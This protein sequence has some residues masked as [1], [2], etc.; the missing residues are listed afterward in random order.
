M[1]TPTGLKTR[2]GRR[3]G[4]DAG[5]Y[6]PPG[7][8]GGLPK[9]LPSGITIRKYESAVDPTLGMRPLLDSLVISDYTWADIQPTNTSGLD[10]VVVAGIHDMLDWCDANTGTS[11][12]PINV[13]LRIEM[14][15]TPNWLKTQTG[16]IPYFIS[17]PTLVEIEGGVCPWW[18]NLDGYWDAYN[19]LDVQ[20][21]A[22]FG[23]HPRLCVR[24]MSLPAIFYNEPS[25]HWWGAA[26]IQNRAAV[27]GR[28]LPA[29]PVP[30]GF[31]PWSI[32]GEDAAFEAGWQSHMETWARYGV[33]C[34]TSYNPNDQLTAKG[35]GSGWAYGNDVT[36]TVKL[37]E[38]QVA[39][40]GRTALLANHSLIEENTAANDT[41]MY[42]RQMAF[43]AASTPF[44]VGIDYQTKTL[45]K[46]VKDGKQ[47]RDTLTLA[48][49][50]G[51]C[52]IE[53]PLGCQLASRGTDQVTPAFAA[54]L[55][56]AMRGNV[57][58]LISPVSPPGGGGGPGGWTTRDP[59]AM[60]AA[61]AAYLIAGAFFGDPDGNDVG[62]TITIT[63]SS[64]TH[65][66]RGGVTNVTVAQIGA[67]FVA[68]GGTA[69][70][71][72]PTPSEYRVIGNLPSGSTIVVGLSDGLVRINGADAFGLTQVGGVWT[73]TATG[74]QVRAFL[75]GMIQGEGQVSGKVADDPTAGHLLLPQ[76]L[77][78]TAQGYS[79]PTTISGA[80]FRSLTIDGTGFFERVQA[81]PFASYSRCPGG[82]P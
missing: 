40:Q 46:H 69:V 41:T 82:A 20:T 55:N 57:L 48:N 61:R 14:E 26:T 19:N 21:S 32:A 76:R 33:A 23:G 38:R 78:A 22:E 67:A 66:R 4:N 80:T 65:M 53:P 70:Y 62:D 18:H 75:A 7:Y 51:A 77:M 73:T 52:W 11:E 15:R 34:E 71:S 9:D 2:F 17:Q 16:A 27:M 5:I 45:A 1:S 3:I 63:S 74:G 12:R 36:R 72:N 54:A 81:Y 30:V 6:E 25:V 60:D 42:E 28:A 13:I 68:L 43:R 10:P 31:T 50:M 56:T 29:D 44:P 37:M 64:N 35:D 79:V 49:T 24:T 58:P 47:V 59:A 39:M 8:V